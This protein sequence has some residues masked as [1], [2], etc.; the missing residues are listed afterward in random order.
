MKLSSLLEARY[1]VHPVIAFVRNHLEAP[2]PKRVLTHE[3]VF[4][5]IDEARDAANAL[6]EL[7]GEPLVE[8]EGRTEWSIPKYHIS[9]SHDDFE[10]TNKN[11][12]KLMVTVWGKGYKKLK[13]ATLHESFVDTTVKDVIK[14]VRDTKRKIE[15]RGGE[16]IRSDTLIVQGKTSRFRS[17]AGH[18]G[19]LINQLTEIYG[20]PE[21][22][23]V[24]SSRGYGSWVFKGGYVNEIQR[25]IRQG[26]GRTLILIHV[27]LVEDDNNVRI[28]NESFPFPRGA[29][30][31][32]FASAVL[33]RGVHIGM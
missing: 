14:S 7:L 10:E 15:R 18:F 4:D 16:I 17:D 6:R 31:Q 19:D 20:R 27:F 24:G 26:G 29:S 21:A 28:Y 23:G 3:H 13:E 12:R 5:T 8:K 9:I 1:H 30:W 2:T 11:L 22:G 33:K 32:R 25:D